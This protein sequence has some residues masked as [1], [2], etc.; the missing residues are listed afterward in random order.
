MPVT[1]CSTDST[2]LSLEQS[3]GG[4][5]TRSW[6]DSSGRAVGPAPRRVSAHAGTW[7]IGTTWPQMPEARGSSQY[8][9]R[10]TA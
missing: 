10:K 3:S 6:G 2:I 8:S 4:S 7:V 9:T 5:S 1:T